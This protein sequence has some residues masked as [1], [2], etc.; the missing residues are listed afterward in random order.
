M[1][2]EVSER[3]IDKPEEAQMEM[4]DEPEQIIPEVKSFKTSDMGQSPELKE[5]LEQLLKDPFNTF[6]ID[7]K[8]NKTSYGILWLGAFVCADCAKALVKAQGGMQHCYIKE[9]F[10]EQWDDY[11]LLSLA[12]G[13]NSNLFNH[14]KEYNMENQS[15]V[16]NYNKPAL[17]W[18]RGQHQAKMDGVVYTKPKPPKDW[19]EALQ[20]TQTTLIKGFNENFSYASKVITEKSANIKESVQ[21]GQAFNKMKETGI[22]ATSTMA[23]KTSEFKTQVAQSESFKNLQAG[24]NKTVSQIGIGA[25][26]LKEKVQSQQFAKNLMGMF[27]QKK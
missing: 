22:N 4:N 26:S 24:T 5:Y 23:M 10:K 11:Q 27:G 19:D 7:C 2:R 16:A 14:L 15:I 13:G 9:I 21:K 18:Y 6:C 25:K 20:Q 3:Q 17:K 8:Q 1:D 12:H